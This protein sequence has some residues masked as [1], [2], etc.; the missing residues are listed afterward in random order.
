MI[1]I[2]KSLISSILFGSFVWLALMA[3]AQ[4][5]TPTVQ[6]KH[7]RVLSDTVRVEWSTQ[8]PAGVTVV[9]F[10]VESQ[11][12]FIGGAKAVL[13]ENAGPK[14]NSIDLKFTPR[15]VPPSVSLTKITTRFTAPDP[16][17]VTTTREF[18]LNTGGVQGGVAS[19]GEQPG[20][21]PVVQI[22]SAVEDV[23]D[24]RPS[25]FTVRWVTTVSAPIR[26]DGY[27]VRALVTYGFK[28]PP[29]H[30]PEELKTDTASVGGAQQQ[31]NL[32]VNNAPDGGHAQ[33]IRVSVTAHF[34]RVTPGP[35]VRAVETQ[36]A[37]TF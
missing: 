15:N 31:A 37:G 2:Q 19:G 36:A 30:P 9:G 11:I 34:H 8:T 28:Q 18:A 5:Q 14:A 3:V 13:S 7:V 35:T 24:A 20:D 21:R 6:I 32:V 16:T 26:I 23:F 22:S 27:E 12:G 1:R 17:T 10:I 4:A 29:P 33:R 25:R